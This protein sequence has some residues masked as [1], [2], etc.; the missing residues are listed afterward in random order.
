MNRQA[1]LR[2]WFFVALAG[3]VAL[4]V[5]STT[6]LTVRGGEDRAGWFSDMV[7]VINLEPLPVAFE[8]RFIDLDGQVVYTFTDTLQPGRAD[9]Y[10]PA[11]MP[12]PL[13][14]TFSGTLV[15]SAP[16]QVAMEVIHFAKTITDSNTVLEGVDSERLSDYSI[17]P[18]DKCVTIG[19][20][21]VSELAAG[22]YLDIFDY[23]GLPVGTI[24]LGMLDPQETIIVRPLYSGFPLDIVGMG[25]IYSTQPIEV[26]VWRICNGAGAFAASPEGYTDLALPLVPTHSVGLVT[27][28]LW[29]Q[30]ISGIM[31][32]SVGISYSDGTSE[33]LLIGPHGNAIISSPFTDTAQAALINSEQPLAAYVL[34]ESRKTG[35]EGSFAYRGI[36][37]EEATNAIALPLLFGG[38]A[39]WRTGDH[40]WVQNVGAE[41][42]TITIR[43]TAAPTGT[44]TWQQGVVAAGDVWR[45]DT[46]AGLG[47]LAGAIAQAD[48]PIVAVAGSVATGL[49]ANAEV[50]DHWLLYRGANYTPTCEL[51]TGIDFTWS[52][53]LP[54]I[55]EG[56]WFSATLAGSEPVSLTW[57]FGDGGSAMGEV[58]SHVYHLV[59]NH[60]VTLSAVNCLGFG[61]DAAAHLLDVRPGFTLYLPLMVRP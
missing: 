11:A 47:Q 34:M 39:G 16:G 44:T 58:V 48:Q 54:I 19:I 49:K 6:L 38:Y 41:A 10:W 22:G 18:I 17:V 14:P 61:S 26:T 52:P 42:A 27:S 53:T 55:G 5:L 51:V 37:L 21:N 25:I 29:L 4:V 7:Q 35:Q 50:D 36:G 20:H 40:L 28:T 1:L 3:I 57:N 23:N 43:Y 32:T 9:I 56:V 13:P 60:V 31:A 59:G 46:P 24:D 8:A 12:T 2:R 15:I 45:V 33:T 30:N